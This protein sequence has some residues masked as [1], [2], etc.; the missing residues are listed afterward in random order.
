MKRIGFILGK[1]IRGDL[2]LGRNKAGLRAAYQLTAGRKLTSVDQWPT[3]RADVLRYDIGSRLAMGDRVFH[4]AHIGVSGGYGITAQPTQVRMAY[5]VSSSIWPGT[6][7]T[8]VT[9]V[10]ALVGARSI[11]YVTAGIFP[12]N[13]F[14]G[15]YIAISGGAAYGASA[16]IQ[17]HPLSAAPGD[18]VVLTLED[19]LPITVPVGSVATLYVSPYYNIIS[20]RQGAIEAIANPNNQRLSICGVP[21]VT[22]LA[23]EYIWVQTWGPALVVSGAGTEGTNIEERELVWDNQDGSVQLVATVRAAGRS[24]QHAG[25]I[26]PATNSAVALP[27]VGVPGGAGG[28]MYMRLQCAP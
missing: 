2:E 15:G 9:G 16:R 5:G 18:T 10:Q 21:L 1:R 20:P 19:P 14:A 8:N 3:E 4:Y 6:D 22:G 28:M 26:I 23:D 7:E 11:Q 13:R 24:F 27:A 25:Y 12:A 17:S